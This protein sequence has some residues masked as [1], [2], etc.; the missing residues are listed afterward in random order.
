MVV[1]Y[2]GALADSP[3]TYAVGQISEDTERLLQI[4]KEALYIGITESQIVVL[5]IVVMTLVISNKKESLWN[6]H[7][8]V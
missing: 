7:A 4:T 8:V 1:N 3:W 6:S 2:N 5:L